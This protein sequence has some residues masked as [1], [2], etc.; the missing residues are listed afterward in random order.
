MMPV[1]V[2]PNGREITASFPLL[3]VLALFFLHSR[4][5]VH[6]LKRH[7]PVRISAFRKETT[8]LSSPSN[9]KGGVSFE[10]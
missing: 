8:V 9:G 4:R 2:S 7:S 10:K 3:A 6:P 1:P 5:N